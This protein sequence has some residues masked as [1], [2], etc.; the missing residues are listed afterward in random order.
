M[1]AIAR[2]TLIGPLRLLAAFVYGGGVEPPPGAEPVEEA[3]PA[4]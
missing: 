3:T 2:M 1:A 4:G